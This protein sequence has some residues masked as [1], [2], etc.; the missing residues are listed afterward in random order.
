MKKIFKQS[1]YSGLVFYTLLFVLALI[2]SGDFSY[3]GVK[4]QSVENLVMDKYL[5]SILLR[6]VQFL[7]V[8]L[9]IG[10][11]SGL[12]TAFFLNE[13]HARFPVIKKT[14]ILN[15]ILQLVLYILAI[16]STMTLYPQMFAEKAAG[17]FLQ[18]LLDFSVNY[19]HPNLFYI[20]VISVFSV[21]LILSF[22]RF[23]KQI[24]LFLLGSLIIF[25]LIRPSNKPDKIVIMLG[26]DSA[27]WDKLSDSTMAPTFS[28]VIKES[29]VFPNVWVDIPRTFPSWTTLMTGQS[30]LQHGIRHMFPTRLDRYQNFPA[31]PKV[32]GSH[33]Y[34]TS[35]I[36]DFAGDIFSRID[37]GF[38][39]VRVPYFNFETLINNRAATIHL[40]IF[41]FVLNQ[42]GR[43]A[44]PE[45]SEMA[46]NPDPYMLRDQVLQQI[47]RDQGLSFITTFWSAAHFPY[48]PPFPFYNKFTDPH[49]TGPNKYQKMDLLGSLDSSAADQQ[50]IANLYDGGIASMDDAFHS[51]IEQLKEKDLLDKTIFV[52]LADHGEH[53]FEPN[54]ATGHGE[55]LRGK[56][57]LNIPFF[58]WN[59]AKREMKVIDKLGSSSDVMPTILDYLQIK[60]DKPKIHNSLLDTSFIRS[61]VYSET[62]LWFTDQGNWFYQK[63]RIMY[64]DVVGLCEMDPNYNDEVV[65][66]DEYKSL[67]LMAK[68]RSWTTNNF[69]LIYIP[70]TDTV[71]YEL[72]DRKNDPDEQHNIAEKNPEIVRQLRDELFEFVLQYEGEA[73]IINDRI[74]VSRRAL[75]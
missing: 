28:K 9:T 45:L 39:T 20:S 3:M 13:L 30:V 49:Y 48:A 58:I 35:V 22:V 18:T 56:N 69:K 6:Q 37:F 21:S 32:L 11:L 14:F 19:G 41:P 10:L 67:T 44:F 62:G 52:I 54:M 71:L 50:A 31:L 72:Y 17:S 7:L 55:H 66:K 61:G 34:H 63:Q 73:F 4:N 43:T 5:T 38:Q 24:G 8:Y 36:S 74:M 40:P 46:N 70:K 1:V 65:L 47:D 75:W 51:L 60:S 33:G 16:I 68:H 64:P 53:L 42:M 29:T 27:R 57:V 23:P 59:P 12:L 15:I 2:F 25:L 26:M